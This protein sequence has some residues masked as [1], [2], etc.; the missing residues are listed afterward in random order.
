[1][2]IEADAQVS[3]MKAGITNDRKWHPRLLGC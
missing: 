2:A 3:C 1:M